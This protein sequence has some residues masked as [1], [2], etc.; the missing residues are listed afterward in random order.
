MEPPKPEDLTHHTTQR[1]PY[2]DLPRVVDAIPAFLNAV[3]RPHMA[4]LYTPSMEVQVIVR[5][6]DGEPVRTEF[7]GREHLAYTNGTVTWSPIRIPRHAATEPEFN[8]DTRMRYPLD[9]YAQGIGMTGYD[10]EHKVSRYVAFDFDSVINHKKGLGIEELERVHTLC[11]EI[12]WVTVLRSTG[13]HG[14]HMYVHID[15]LDGIANHTEHAAVARAIL[16][17]MSALAGFDFSCAVDALGGNMWIWHEKQTASSYEIVKEG[18][19]LPASE[20]P[21]N[22]RAHIAVVSRRSTRTAIRIRGSEA[23]GSDVENY[24]A[25]RVAVPLDEEHRT[26]IQA[27]EG[28]QSWWDSDHHILITHTSQLAHVHATKGLRGLFSTIATGKLGGADH[29]CFCSPMPNGEWA[30]RRYGKGI[31]E[32]E[33][34]F[35]DANGWTT[36]YYNR[37]PDIR[38]AAIA[39]SGVETEKRG[40]VF[41][42]AKSM[43]EAIQHFGTRLDVP[44][45]VQ[46]RQATIKEHKDGRL[47]VKINRNADDSPTLLSG[48]EQSK[49]K[50]WTKIV[51]AARR[52]PTHRDVGNFDN[53]VRHIVSEQRADLGWMLNSNDMFRREPIHHVKVALRSLGHSAADVETIVGRATLNPWVIVNKPFQPEYPGGRE[54]NPYAP[55]FAFTPSTDHDLL[56]YPTWTRVLNH[57]GRGLDA[58]VSDNQWCRD[59]GILTG[60]DYLKCWIASCFQ[61]P[62]EPTPYLFFFGPQN[63]GKTVFHESLQLL[64][65]AGYVSAKQ[66]LQ[67]RDGFNGELQH[68]VICSIEEI[69]LRRNA[70]AY[71]RIKDWVTAHTISI[72][73]KHGTPELYINTTHWI[74]CANDRNY[75]HIM[76][77]DT[78]IVVAQVHPIPQSDFLPRRDLDALL[79]AEAPDFLAEVLR[80]E[81]PR[82]NDRLALPAIMTNA[83]R[84]MENNNKGVVQR[85]L[86]DCVTYSAG[87]VVTLEEAY[88]SFINWADPMEAARYSKQKFTSEIPPEV[89]P[90]GRIGTIQTGPHG[91]GN[92]SLEPGTPDLHPGDPLVRIPSSDY[93][94]PLSRV[95]RKEQLAAERGKHG[96]PL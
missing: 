89:H 23:E 60:A 17:K 24:T 15:G 73:P 8:L 54:W 4:A 10:W 61:N 46:H 59:N 53:V 58:A 41:P 9:L 26:V 52:A 64:L 85:W 90:K 51:A 78:R 94:I 76:P 88:R 13:G 33:V 29:N 72:H 37:D 65:S 69:D 93:L 21:Q 79:R 80:L 50:T 22:W 55:Q 66:A 71:N 70:E 40:F 18:C 62:T 11:C 48:W 35:Q 95:S 31:E 44:E 67:S 6:A 63:T 86:D 96:E 2:G 84:E 30:V 43:L 68:A 25:Q 47:I 87:S 34:W 39:Y 82:S 49:D 75:C 1:L 28:T 83:K 16:A 91:L 32:T 5:R 45:H 20:V 81:I 74:Q 42:T 7:R 19:M 36:T 92:M 77:G 14:Y 3:A 12:P 57:V 56:S 27:L 38:T